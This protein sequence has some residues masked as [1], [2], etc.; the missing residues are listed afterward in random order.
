MSEGNTSNQSEDKSQNKFTPHKL[1]IIGITIVL[2]FLIVWSN[3]TGNYESVTDIVL[4]LLCVD[5][6]LILATCLG[7]I[8]F[9]PKIMN[10]IEREGKIFPVYS[11]KRFSFGLRYGIRPWWYHLL[12]FFVALGLLILLFIFVIRYNP[13]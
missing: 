9:P 11:S 8:M 2:V 12:M 7:K 13:T 3:I 6:S 10:K 5:F 4:M 1:G